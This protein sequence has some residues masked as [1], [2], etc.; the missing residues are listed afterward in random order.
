MPLV[1][2]IVKPLSEAWELE[3]VERLNWKTFVEEIPQHAPEEGDGQ[4]RLAD[5]LLLKSETF[6][7]IAE[8]DVCGMVAVSGERPFSLDRK[9]PD[10][11]RYLPPHEKPCEIR[12][13]AVD[14]RYRGARGGLVFSHLLAALIAHCQTRGY[15]LGLISA[16][17]SQD[18]LYRH[19]GFVPFGPEV[20]TEQAP[21]RPMW[22]TWDRVDSKALRLPERNERQTS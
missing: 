15:D 12:R 22:L 18:R 19:L 11:D 17:R 21:Y 2:P 1:R 6:V 3:G 20:G 5:K 16:A 9:L 14:P 7:A 4:G 10:L 13:L 8:S